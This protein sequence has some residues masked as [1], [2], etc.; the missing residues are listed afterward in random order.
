MSAGQGDFWSRAKS[1]PRL[2]FGCSFR[3]PSECAAVPA[4]SSECGR[5][6][7][8]TADSFRYDKAFLCIG[9]DR[10]GLPGRPE[11]AL[12]ND[13]VGGSNPS[14]GTIPLARSRGRPPWRNSL[15]AGNFAGKFG[16]SRVGPVFLAQIGGAASRA[17]GKFPVWQR[18]EFVVP[19][20]DMFR[21]G[22]G[23]IEPGREL[24]IAVAN[25]MSIE[26]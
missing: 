17:C 3:A 5:R 19:G 24:T 18:R 25:R 2:H 1:P 15:S 21:R 9:A 14:C 13:G 7:D 6:R 16:E 10:S 26:S 22:Q 23:I 4:S 12:R 11:F 8:Q 20:R